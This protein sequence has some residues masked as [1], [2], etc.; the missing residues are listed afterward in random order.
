VTIRIALAVVA[1]IC[2]VLAA[3]RAV[4]SRS[5]DRAVSEPPAR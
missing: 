1:V 5:R 4:A 2:A 3:R